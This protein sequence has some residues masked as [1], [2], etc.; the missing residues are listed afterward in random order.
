MIRFK[1]WVDQL[2]SVKGTDSFEFFKI[3]EVFSEDGINYYRMSSGE[4]FKEDQLISSRPIK[5]LIEEL[6]VQF[7]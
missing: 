5:E 6:E 2:V 1:Y 3:V 7:L 4:E